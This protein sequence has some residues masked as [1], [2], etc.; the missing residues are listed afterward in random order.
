MFHQGQEAL[1]GEAA[2][3]RTSGEAFDAAFEVLGL[4]SPRVGRPRK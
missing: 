3:F 1:S 2:P 4:K